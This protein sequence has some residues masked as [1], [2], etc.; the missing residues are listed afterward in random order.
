MMELRNLNIP[1]DDLKSKQHLGAGPADGWVAERLKNV[2][3]ELAEE[4]TCDEQLA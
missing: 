2:R 1:E 4:V 3:V